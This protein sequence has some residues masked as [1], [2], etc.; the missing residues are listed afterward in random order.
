MIGWRAR[1]G[2]LVPSANIVLENDLA[3]MAPVGVSV[4]FTRI[5]NNEDTPEELEA[6]IDHVPKCVEL[7]SHA[8]MDV[9]AFGCTGGS[10]MGGL[11]YDQRI[12]KIIEDKTS[13]PATS[14]S[15]AV[16]QGLQELGI[17]RISV[18]T[19]YEDWLNE[20]LKSFLTAN[21]VAVLALKGLGIRQGE[22]IAGQSPEAIYRLSRE[23]DRKESQAIF[24]SCTNMRALEVLEKIEEDLGKPAISSNQATFWAMLRLA[25]L[26]E[27]VPGYGSLLTRL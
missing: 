3:Q 24:V 9:Y 27:P 16:L 8:R 4:H 11:G 7:L 19:P 14:T 17:S 21:G 15:T 20:K 10:L 23:V 12:I 26:K 25:R 5:W 22:A 1:L 18:V 6:M 2:V 13:K